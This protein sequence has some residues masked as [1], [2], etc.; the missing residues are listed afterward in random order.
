MEP[1]Q[2]PTPVPSAPV[3]Q[4]KLS[5]PAA[6]VVAG[7]IIAIAIFAVGFGGKG[8]IQYDQNGKPIVSINIKDVN[9][10]GAPFIGNPDA[11]PIAYYADYQCPFCKKF[12]QENLSVIKTNYVDTGKIRVVFKDFVFLGPDS[13]DAALYAR[14][15]WNLYPNEYFAWREAMFTAQDEEHSG[16]GNRKSI[17]L[18]TKTIPGID[19]AKISANL[20]ANNDAYNKMVEADYV[21][22]Q[23]LGVKGT[24]SVIIGKVIIDGA[25]PIE[26]Y[27]DALKKVVK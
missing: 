14:A 23:K 25:Y 2:T 19:Q 15:V 7:L 9:L 13:I 3:L 17:E 12:E 27:T 5:V 16:F 10:A 24:P 22:G 11:T 18:L 1:T 6:I 20:D 21:E 8:G 4:L 26:R